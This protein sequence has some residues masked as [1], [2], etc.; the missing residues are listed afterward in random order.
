MDVST[1]KTA[2]SS[3]NS[4]YALLGGL[5]AVTQTISYEVNLALVLLYLYVY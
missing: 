1:L 5:W 2:G 4:N 3:S